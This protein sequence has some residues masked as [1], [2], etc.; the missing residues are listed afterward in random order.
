MSKRILRIKH[1]YVAVKCLSSGESVD[2]DRVYDSVEHMF[3]KLFGEVSL[4]NS[5][6]RRIRVKRLERHVLVIGCSHA[7]L[8]KVL[9]ALTLVNSVDGHEVALDVITVSGTL[10]S[11]KRKVMQQV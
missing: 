4:V 6:L 9:T 8:G 2:F 11:L 1:R 7:Y 5:R 3:T 10:R